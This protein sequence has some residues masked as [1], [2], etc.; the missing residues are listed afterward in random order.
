MTAYP[1]QTL[2]QTTLGQLCTALWD[3]QSQPVVMQPEIEPECC[4][5]TA[6]TEM[7]CL[8]PLRHSGAQEMVTLWIFPG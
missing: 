5:D 8:T 1:V 2:T 6:S 3:S 4:S 7:Q